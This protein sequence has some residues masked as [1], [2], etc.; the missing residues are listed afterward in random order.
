MAQT[1]QTLPTLKRLQH[2]PT[3]L[4]THFSLG[5][6]WRQ[7]EIEALV[8]TLLNGPI[9]LTCTTGRML[10]EQTAA[11]GAASSPMALRSQCGVYQF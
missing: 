6:V 10:V 5:E 9:P 4:P 8:V 2:M 3:S 11:F 7:L 1:T